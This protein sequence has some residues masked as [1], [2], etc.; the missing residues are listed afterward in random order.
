MT[1]NQINRKE[2]M[3]AVLSFL[4]NNAA[5]WTPI[6]KVGEFKNQLAEVY[7]QIETSQQAQQESKVY[8][9]KNKKQLKK[10]IAEKGDILNDGAEAYAVVAEDAELENRM[11][12][13]YS[14]L[15]D[16]KNADFVA[17]II[18]IIKE[19]EKHKE[20]LMAEYGVTEEQITDLKN[21]VDGFLVLQGKPRAYSISTT[22]ATKDLETLFSDSNKILKL[23][24][25]KVMKLF[26]RRDANFYNG[27]LAARVVVDD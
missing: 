20:V 15:H 18:E 10:T 26:K 1:K 13:S 25:D 22:Q 3:E 11:A 6:P 12:K 27:Y 21:D 7:G 24:L 23:K 17:A 4:D 2:M 16:L 8:L 9:G 5:K 14:D 19:V